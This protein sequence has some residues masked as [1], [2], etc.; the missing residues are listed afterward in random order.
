MKE[1]MKTILQVLVGLALCAVIGY[2]LAYSSMPFFWE[3]EE[4]LQPHVCSITWRSGVVL[5]LLLA[6]TQG[7]SFLVFR[8]VHW[9]HTRTPDTGIKPV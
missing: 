8:C 1:T 9:G 4:P 2:A 5:V 3:H 6:A 7:I